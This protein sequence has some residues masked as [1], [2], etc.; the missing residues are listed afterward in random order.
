MRREEDCRIPWNLVDVFVNEGSGISYFAGVR[1]AL[2]TGCCYDHF[3]DVYF[4]LSCFLFSNFP[5]PAN[6]RG[7][8]G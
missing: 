4:S 1:D 3:I 7:G 2:F 5:G 8:E 6:K